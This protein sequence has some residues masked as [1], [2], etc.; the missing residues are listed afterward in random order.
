VGLEFFEAERLAREE[1]D[2]AADDPVARDGV[3]GDPHAPHH[4]VL[5]LV[6]L[7][8]DPHA[9]VAR[10]LPPDPAPRAR[11]RRA[12]V[13]PDETAQPVLYFVLGVD[14][15]PGGDFAVEL[16]VRPRESLLPS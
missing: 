6:D 10:E 16:E 13:P 2:V 12:L 9:S 14:Y 7:V 15:T 3:A 11:C 4:V 1:R 5:L 8:H